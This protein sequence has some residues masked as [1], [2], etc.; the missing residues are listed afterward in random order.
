MGTLY[1]YTRI[2]DKL[3]NRNL[4]N[5]PIDLRVRFYCLLV[6]ER[7]HD[8]T[9]LRLLVV[10]PLG[11]DGLDLRVEVDARLSIEVDVA[12]DRRTRAREREHGER[13][14]DRHVDTNLAD[15]D[16]VLELARGSTRGRENGGTVAIR[17]GVDQLNGFFQRIH[18]RA[19][20]HGAE[21]FLCVGKVVSA[22]V[23]QHGR[24]DE[25]AVRVLF[26]LDT[27]AVEQAFG[28]L[29][30]TSLDQAF[31][32][33][34][35]FHSDQWT[36]VS[37]RLE[38]AVHLE[39]LGLFHDVVDPF[40]GL[41]DEDHNRKSH[42]T[43]TSSAKGSASEGADGLLLVAIWEDDSVILG[44]EVSL[45]ALAVGTATSVDVFAGLVAANERDSLHFRRIANEVDS[46]LQMSN[47][48]RC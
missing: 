15:V 46:I 12:T 32:A 48:S 31:R 30:D 45:H 37:A 43:L 24:T 27:T 36:H 26:N 9:V 35:G 34:L 41:A 1:V 42:A 6:A 7:G 28:A 22:H 20:Q 23:V 8:R 25:V 47:T 29:I 38:A 13:Y 11:R 18:R 3:F 2:L 19:A 4:N 5:Q 16:F 10:F 40:L 44:T 17:V 39:L 33:F 21:D 14:R